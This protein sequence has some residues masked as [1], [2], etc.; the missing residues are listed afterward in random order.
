MRI[1]LLVLFVLSSFFLL[2]QT[3]MSVDATVNYINNKFSE[4]PFLWQSTFHTQKMSYQLSVESNG[5]IKV[6]YTDEYPNKET[7]DGKEEFGFFPKDV[8]MT[9]DKTSSPGFFIVKVNCIKGDCILEKSISGPSYSKDLDG[10]YNLRA[11]YFPSDLTARSVLNA[12]SH[13]CEKINLDKIYSQKEN[14]NDPFAPKREIPIEIHKDTPGT[15]EPNVV[16]MI[17]ADGVFQI[18]VVINDVLKISFI[19][20]SGSSDISISPDVALTLIKTGTLKETDFIGSQTYK[21]AD[22]STAISQT[23]IIRQ[24][25]IGNKILKNIRASISSTIDSP[26]LLG[27]SVLERFGT[28]TIDNINHTIKFD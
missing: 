18:P 28:F 6:I 13:L 8:T 7:P 15:S 1:Y 10:F 5:L 20:D 25:S 14:N 22:G 9:Y 11:I 12:L 2:G 16:K 24:L 17:K 4:N 21:F 19:F 3:D 26:M 23:F 27:Q